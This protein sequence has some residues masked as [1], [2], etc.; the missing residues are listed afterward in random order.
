MHANIHKQR[1]ML[2]TNTKATHIQKHQQIN[3]E[4]R[5]KQP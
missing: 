3:K 4:I 2:E 5:D 1:N